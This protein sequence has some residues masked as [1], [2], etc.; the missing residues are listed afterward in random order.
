MLFHN[1]KHK[2]AYE[3]LSAFCTEAMGFGPAAED[4][5][6]FIIRDGANLIVILALPWGEEQTV[7]QLRALM[8]RDV[9]ISLKAAKW[10]LENND[11]VVLGAFG[12]TDDTGLFFGYTIPTDGLTEAGLGTAIAAVGMSARHYGPEIIERFGGRPFFAE[13]N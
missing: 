8:V 2:D 3:T 13:E 5:P 6:G 12:W 9:P 1:D 7:F 10:L 4:S 11:D